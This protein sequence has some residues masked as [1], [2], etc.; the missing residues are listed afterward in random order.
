MAGPLAGLRVV[1][2][3]GIGPG[4]LAAM[5]LA[6][7]GADVVRIDR[8]S[9]LPPG[10]G[11]FGADH[12]LRGRTFV[13]ADLS[14]P[15]QRDDVLELISH[16]DVLIEGF[17]PGV[18]EKLGLSPTDTAARNPRLVY[19]RMTGWG[20]DGPW[21]RRAGHDI[22][23]ISVTG[24]LNAIRTAGARPTVP[25]NLVGDYGGG[26]MFLLFGILSALWERDRSGQGQVVDAAMV[27][28]VTA[29][30]QQFWSFRAG[31]AWSDTPADNVLDSGAP[32]YD[33]YV[34]SDGHYVAV[35]AIEP[36]FFAE[37]LRGLELDAALSQRQNDRS[38]WSQLRTLFAERFLTHGRDHWAEVF[39][40][41]DACVTPVLSFDEATRHPHLVQR[42]SHVDIGGV[43]QTAAAPRFSRSAPG[44]PRALANDFQDVAD[45]LGRWHNASEHG[46]TE[47][48]ST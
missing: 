42:G 26:S 40:D 4:P 15:A 31:G 21:S 48:S 35:G 29:L 5:L 1:E 30:L 8:P 2:L 11:I 10:T 34:C 41:T 36:Q 13:Q 16:A 18:T 9:E 37:L 25:L 32:F 20:Q 22:N 44:S 7:L 38:Q 43:V 45:V 14:D 33:T 19:A 46:A 47:Q 17:R 27:D 23:Y 6:D 12:T 24:A 3:G 39:A 28:G